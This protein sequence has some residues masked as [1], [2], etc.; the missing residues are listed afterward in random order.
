MR[1][2]FRDIKIIDSPRAKARLFYSESFNQIIYIKKIDSARSISKQDFSHKKNGIK[3]KMMLDCLRRMQ[4]F[5]GTK[6]GYKLYSSAYKLMVLIAP[7]ISNKVYRYKWALNS[8]LKTK[9]LKIMFGVFENSKKPAVNIAGSIFGILLKQYQGW[10]DICNKSLN[11]RNIKPFGNLKIKIED[12]EFICSRLKQ[13]YYRYSSREILKKK[14]EEELKDLD[15][16]II[17]HYLGNNSN[18]TPQIN[19]ESY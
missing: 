8:L 12:L 15:L 5:N 18:S 16:N 1:L 13:K 9:H 10:Y 17:V 14:Y 19:W 7:N 2:L 6:K 4:Q 3:E 11:K